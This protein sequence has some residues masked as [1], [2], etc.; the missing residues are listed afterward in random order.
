MIKRIGMFRRKVDLDRAAFSKHWATTHRRIVTTLPGMARY[1]QNHVYEPLDPPFS[2]VQAYDID[3][4]AEMWWESEAAMNATMNEDARSRLMRD[5]ANFIERITIF[6]VEEERQSVNDGTVKVIVPMRSVV[7]REAS[8]K[9]WRHA[10]R[11]GLPHLRTSVEG[12]VLEVRTRPHLPTEMVAPDC[13][14]ELRFETVQSA[15]AAVTSRSGRELMADVGSVFT[16]FGFHF[17]AE[18]RM[19]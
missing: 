12:R 13:F 18:H 5:E 9:A 16:R 8:A 3:G 7:G 4:I 19:L 15:E 14:M 1:V 2:S 17:M 10:L 11:A 6:L